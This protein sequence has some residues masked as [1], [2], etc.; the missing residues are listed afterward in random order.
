M[1]KTNIKIEELI[2]TLR[3][4]KCKGLRGFRAHPRSCVASNVD[5]LKVLFSQSDTQKATRKQRRRR[6]IN[7]IPTRK[8][9]SERRHETSD[10]KRGMTNSEYV[11]PC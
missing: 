9:S 11:L 2:M 4:K 8:N 5:D 7:T 3:V 6:G 10:N 1:K